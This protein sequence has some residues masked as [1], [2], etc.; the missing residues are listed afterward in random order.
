[1][2]AS[3]DLLMLLNLLEDEFRDFEGVRVRPVFKSGIERSYDLEQDYDPEANDV[4]KRS[5]VKV[6]AGK[7]EYFF[8][9]EWVS[10]RM[11]ASIRDQI[12]DIRSILT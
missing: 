12:E 8:P 9:E 11:T 1:M 7:K 4:H 5:G 6:M 3:T 10:S 2:N